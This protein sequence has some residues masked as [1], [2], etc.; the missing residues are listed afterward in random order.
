MRSASAPVNSPK[1]VFGGGQRLLRRADARVDAGAQS[2][3]MPCTS[4]LSVSSSEASRCQR[5]LGVG[6]QR[7]LALDVL[8]EL[9]QA[10][11][12]LGEP[13][14]GAGL[15]LVERVARADQALQR[16]AGA[17]LGVAQRRHRD[18]GF[19]A[20]LAGLGLR[21]GGVGDGAHAEVLGAL[22]VARLRFAR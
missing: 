8:G 5:G 17:H 22:G 14:A 20:L 10:A 6:H 11:L 3:A 12:E 18:G 7:A 21:D 19:L 2:A 9:N 13:L 1:V 4:C 16:G 15:L